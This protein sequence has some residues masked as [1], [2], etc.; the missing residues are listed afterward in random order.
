MP[1]GS[2]KILSCFVDEAGDF[3]KYDP[4]CPYYIISVVLH[5]QDDSIEPQLQGMEQYLTDLGFPH[6][7]LHTG[8]LV[9]RESDYINMQMED[10]KKMFNLLF[11][12]ARKIPI[13]YFSVKVR[14]SECKDADDLDAKLTK[15]IKKEVLKEEEYWNS[16]DKIIIYYDNGQKA[17]KR[18]L[19]ITFNSLFRDVELR[20]VQPADYRLFQV[21]DLICTL[22]LTL[23]KI[24][25]GLFTKTDYEFFHGSHE[26]KKEYWRKIEKL[27]M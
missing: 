1:K 15:A 5:D 2:P 9:R 22:E 20:K 23:S 3:G 18:V 8:P 10:R 24:E 17:L 21:A 6:H 11:N 25:H 14:K 26:F 19:N 7:A 4:H 12:F 16:F 27:K 13:H